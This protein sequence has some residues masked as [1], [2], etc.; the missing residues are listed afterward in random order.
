MFLSDAI[1]EWVNYRT[2]AGY[3]PATVRAGR[4]CLARYLA[5]TGNIRMRSI[6]VKHGET[7]L[8]WMLTRGYKPRSVNL[9]LS[10]CNQFFKWARSRRLI[11]S[12]EDPMMNTRHQRVSDAPRLR[13]PVR[14]FTRVL[15][16]AHHPQSRIVV[17]FGL[18]LFTRSSEIEHLKVGDVDLDAGEIRLYQPK[19]KRWD[20]MPV[21]S[22]LDQEVR[23][24]LT[25]Y[26]RDVGPLDPTWPLVPRRKP[27]PFGG[28]GV[29][30]DVRP[31]LNVTKPAV[32]LARKVQKVLQDAG[33]TVAPGDHEGVHTLRRSGARAL[34]DELEARGTRD[35]AL[36]YVSS[37]LHHKSVV[38]TETYLGLEVDRER[39]DLL[40]RG[41]TMFTASLPENVVPIEKGLRTAEES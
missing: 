23:R 17:A 1:D 10:M 18:Y 7:F 4:E 5:S 36:R 19:T 16:S 8:A 25:W 26:T 37:M 2:G 14:E 30:A 28:N 13:I 3:A 39:R 6:T 35:G 38:Q 34:F 11:S 33:Y 31:E 22:E 27:I 40:L 12:N 24:W 29:M 21:C 9:H 41:K 15:E 20:V 32:H